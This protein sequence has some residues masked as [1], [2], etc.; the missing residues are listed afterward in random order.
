MLFNSFL[1][2]NK[3]KNLSFCGILYPLFFQ[4]KF[5][6]QFEVIY[7]RIKA[8]VYKNLKKRICEWVGL[9]TIATVGVWGV[10]DKTG[11]QNLNK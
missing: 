1:N 11:K 8:F 5:Y 9:V 3:V 4:L 10:G 7:F 6:P 2:S